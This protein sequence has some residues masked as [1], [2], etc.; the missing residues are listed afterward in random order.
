MRFQMG[1]LGVDLLTVREA[2]LVYPPLLLQRRVQ[3]QLRVGQ[4][5]GAACGGRFQRHRGGR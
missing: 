2:A 3:P 5:Q 4:G 1:A